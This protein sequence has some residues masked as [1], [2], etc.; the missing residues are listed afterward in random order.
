ML[1][2]APAGTRTRVQRLSPQHLSLNDSGRNCTYYLFSVLLP[3]EQPEL[4]WAILV[5]DNA[6]GQ[7]DGTEEEGTH[8]KGQVQHLILV[9]TDG[10]AIHLEVLLLHHEAL[11]DPLFI[12]NQDWLRLVL[13]GAVTWRHK[14]TLW[15][16]QIQLHDPR[17]K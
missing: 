6:Q 1:C 11:G 10:P 5:H 3:A 8:S 13:T 2:I 16:L 14:R 17:G 7:G 4:A 12:P 15:N 9:L